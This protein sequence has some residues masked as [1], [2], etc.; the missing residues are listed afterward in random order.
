MLYCLIA[1]F[2]IVL[3]L[4]VELVGLNNLIPYIVPADV[5]VI[6]SIVLPFTV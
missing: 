2:E 6:L 4:K 1:K 3:L 5:L